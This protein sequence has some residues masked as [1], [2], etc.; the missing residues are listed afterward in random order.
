MNKNRLR[1]RLSN[2]GRTL[3]LLAVF[4][5][6]AAQN[7]G[8]NLLYLMSSC[9]FACLVM[10]GISSLRNLAGLKV[11]LQL[12]E[13]CFAGQEYVLRC[14]IEDQIGRQHHCLAFE[15]DFVACLLPGSM[16]IL[17]TAISIPVRGQFLV[18][19]LRLFSFYPVDIFFTYIEMPSD[20]FP[21]GPI[22]AKVVPDMLNRDS[23]GRIQKQSAG[24]EGDYWM[25]SHYREG[26]DASMI[27]W[28]ISARSSQEWVLVKSVSLGSSSRL[29]FDFSGLSPDAFEKSL[30]IIAGLL[31]K[32]QAQPN[33]IFIWGNSFRRGYSW[34]SLH[35]DM[36]RIVR[37]LACLSL[38]EEIPPASDA[39][40]AV[41][42]SQWMVMV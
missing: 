36:P 31:I 26:D 34:L 23:E 37:W 6:F 35:H 3:F 32:M 4:L 38:G 30:Q 20:A 24:K 42:V 17:K 14:R 12:P 27:N 29:Y 25:Q 18:K 15:D 22:P 9:F 28:K 39:S 16:A 7:T 21:A 1:F 19:Q 40:E 41:K 8:N 2:A 33:E 13:F 5:L 10:A 11:D